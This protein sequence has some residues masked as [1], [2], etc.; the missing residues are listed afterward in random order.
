VTQIWGVDFTSAPRARKP[1]MVVRAELMETC[2]YVQDVLQL[3]NLKDFG[4]WLGETRGVIGIDAPLG[5]PRRLL[6][7]LAEHNPAWTE[8]WASYVNVISQLTKAE[9][10]DVLN[11]YRASRPTGDKQHLRYCDKL[12]GACSP[13]MLYGVP[14]AKMFFVLA[15]LLLAA[16]VDVP[17]LRPILTSV[18]HVLEV[19]PAL[20][21]QVL[22]KLMPDAG[23]RVSYKSDVVSKQTQTQHNARAQMITALSQGAL[24]EGYGVRL[25]LPPQLQNAM[26]DDPKGDLLDALFAAIQAAWAS[27]QDNFGI[28]QDTDALEGWISDPLLSH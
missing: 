18:C 3:T 14:V 5:Q 4:A 15:P 16:K 26:I 8:S 9:F 10:E 13:M 23:Q 11:A 19:Y 27:G 1:I 12:A 25:E 22:A 20:V 21:V 7:N 2:V 28:P 17:L 24:D 6:T